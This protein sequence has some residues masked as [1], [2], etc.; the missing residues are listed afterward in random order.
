[1]F[2]DGPRNPSEFL[3]Y[4]GT[5]GTLHWRILPSNMFKDTKYNAARNCSMWNGRQGGK[6]AFTATDSHGYRQGNFFGVHMLIHKLIWIIEFGHP[7]TN[8]ID[9]I[10]GDRKNIKI[11]N[12]RDVSA[13]ID[14]R[15]AG[16]KISNT[17]GHTG[18]SFDKAK[19]RWKAE[20]KVCGVSKFLGRFDKVDDAAAAYESAKARYG[21]SPRHGMG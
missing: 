18:V 17:S 11:N 6:P 16:M 4:D 20:I 1:M 14:G 15:N 12:L 10:D 5:S 3:L 21:F 2:I 9:Y 7:P 8:R 13:L 19:G